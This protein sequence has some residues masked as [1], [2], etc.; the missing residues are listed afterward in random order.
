MILQL[1]SPYFFNLLQFNY[2]FEFIIISSIF[3]GSLFLGLISTYIFRK[4]NILD[5]PD[6]IR[7]LHLTP[8]PATGGLVLFILFICTLKLHLTFYPKIY[9]IPSLTIIFL[10]GLLDDIFSLP[11][12][13]KLITELL[14]AFLIS[15]QITDSIYALIFSTF[16]YATFINSVNFIDNSTGVCLSF[17]VFAFLLLFIFTFHIIYLYYL[18]TLVALLLL[19]LPSEKLFLGNSGTFFIS[20][21]LIVSINVFLEKSFYINTNY[22]LSL[23][24]IIKN[25]FFLFIPILDFFF[26]V[27]RRFYAG[28]PIYKADTRHI[29]FMIEKIFKNKEFALIFWCLF[30]YTILLTNIILVKN[31][32]PYIY[33]APK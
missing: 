6:G 8:T 19:N 18:V 29:S 12:L 30:L 25:L 31:N 33:S 1:L 3:L 26:T 14:V 28:V 24:Y 9:Y 11:V 16:F 15:Y 27:I 13:P 17:L 23:G 21:Y 20:T 7:K 10:L 22:F 4:L 5:K 2:F 32:I